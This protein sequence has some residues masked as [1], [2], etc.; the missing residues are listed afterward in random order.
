MLKA[1]LIEQ[2]EKN[3]DKPPVK[4]KAKGGSQAIIQVA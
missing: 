2:M 1:D 3:K 4:L